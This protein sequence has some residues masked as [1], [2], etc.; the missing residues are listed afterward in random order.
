MVENWDFVKDKTIRGINPAVSV[1]DG[2][3]WCDA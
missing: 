1:P 2:D 3:G